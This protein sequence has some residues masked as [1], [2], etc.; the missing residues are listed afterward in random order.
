MAP[1]SGLRAW[2]TRPPAAA[3]AS[4]ER[5]REQGAETLVHPLLRI[6]ALDL[7]PALRQRLREA[8]FDVVVLSSG[9]AARHLVRTLGDTDAKGRPWPVAAV[10][11]ATAR[12]A[13]ALGLDLRHVSA[14]ATASDLAGE[15]LRQNRPRRVLLPGSDLQRPTLARRLEEGGVEVVPLTLFRTR[16]V[17]ALADAVVAA[18]REG[19]LDLLV[20][21]SPSAVDAWRSRRP[22]GVD[23]PLAAIGETTASRVRELGLELVAVPDAPGEGPL[24]DAVARW[25]RGDRNA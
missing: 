17:D 21:Y 23:L 14:R 11:G 18:L 25:W 2:I 16:S 9:N 20:A 24:L 13:E 10:G 12:Q 8:D 7:E 3:E 15:L 1:L 4:A 22:Q 5:W 6:E 19:R